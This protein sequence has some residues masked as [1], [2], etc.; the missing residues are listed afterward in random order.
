LHY[1]VKGGSDRSSQI[2][3]TLEHYEFQLICYKLVTQTKKLGLPY[4]HLSVLQNPMGKF[5]LLHTL[6]FCN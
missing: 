1:L 2:S 4:I 5:N 3:T 6:F